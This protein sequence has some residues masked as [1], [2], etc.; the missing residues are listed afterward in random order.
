MSFWDSLVERLQQLGE[1]I[2]EWGILILA[3]I[4]VLIVGRWLIGLIRTWTE[5]LLSAG[6]LEPVWKRSG[7]SAALANTDQTPASIVAT[8]VYA[9]LMVGLFLI[10]TRILRITTI[11]NL[12]ERLLAWIP[13]IVLAAVIV[14]IAAA[15]ANWTA[16]LVRPFAEET[17]VGWLARLV[18]IGIILFGVLFALEL[19][20]IQ[21]AEDIVK[22]LFIAAGAAFAIAFGVG[23]IDTAK[24]WWAKHGEPSDLGTR[25]PSPPPPPP[26]P[27]PAGPG[28]PGSPP[29]T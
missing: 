20:R 26:P 17:G 15:I 27:T 29:T 8:I 11:E 14:I 16:N 2:V 7:V 21:F 23:G 6:F 28:G 25:A 3:A 18:Q 9:Y 13:L 19:L 4:L 24:K 12:L 10:V 5:K 1:L 22:I